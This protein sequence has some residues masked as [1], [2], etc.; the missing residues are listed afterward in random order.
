MEQNG[1]G[2]ISIATML[3]MNILQHHLVVSDLTSF[4][5]SDGMGLAITKWP[6]FFGEG[7]IIYPEVYPDV[8]SGNLT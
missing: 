4:N 1:Y 7:M 6:N 3:G 2:S 5:V 8:P